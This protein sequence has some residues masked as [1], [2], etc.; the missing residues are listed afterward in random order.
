MIRAFIFDLDGTLL[1]RDASLK[2]FISTQYDRIPA[3]H[4]M[5]KDEYIQRFVELDKRGYVW[6]DKVYQQ[7]VQEYR[8]PLAWEELL[9]DY[10]KGFRRHCI[11][12]PNLHDMLTYMKQQGMRLGIITNG[13]GEFQNN[14]IKELQI[15]DYFDAILISEIEQIRKPDPAI[16]LRAADRLG[17]KPEEAVY[18]GDHPEND[19]IAS[20][21]VGM[22]GIWKEDL[23]FDDN[24]ERDGTI[25]DLSELIG[26]FLN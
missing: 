15:E 26:H 14:N 12:F 18:V 22:K 2:D 4:S 13:F 16:F 24:F 20:R 19:V 10:V 1:D 7:L 6:K 11:G 9:D 21:Q 23:Y 8:L 3:L 25:K 5:N 17:V